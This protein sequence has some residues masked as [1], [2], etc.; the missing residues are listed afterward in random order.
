MRWKLGLMV[1]ITKPSMVGWAGL[2]MRGSTR[3]RV[4][5]M[6]ISVPVGVSKKV[7]EPLHLMRSGMKP[8]SRRQSQR[9]WPSIQWAWSSQNMRAGSTNLRATAGTSERAACQRFTRRASPGVLSSR[10]STT[11]DSMLGMYRAR[12]GVLSRMPAKAAG[13]GKGTVVTTSMSIE[14]LLRRPRCA[15]RAL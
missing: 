5:L 3:V 1:F 9:H 7:V 4:P 14:T 10:D 8:I 2:S 13:R 12:S 6:R 15:A 11:T